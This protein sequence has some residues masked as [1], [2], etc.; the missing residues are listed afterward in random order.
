VASM[1][2]HS[3]STSTCNAFSSR[4]HLP[5]LTTGRSG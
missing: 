5:C 2:D 3:S 4:F 1:L